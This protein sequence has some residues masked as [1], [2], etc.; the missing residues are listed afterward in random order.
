LRGARSRARPRDAGAPVGR[1]LQE[2]RQREAGHHGA[3]E[4]G[5]G[6]SAREILERADDVVHAALAK[7][8]RHAFEAGGGI[9]DIFGGDRHLVLEFAGGPM[10]RMGEAAQ[11]L[12][13]GGFLL[14]DDAAGL[15]RHA[16]GKLRHLI[17]RVA[18]RGRG[19]IAQI[20]GLRL[21]LVRQP[22]GLAPDLVHGLARVPA[23]FL[24]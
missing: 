5:D 4:E 14:L 10:H 19:L 6:L 7:G 8:P 24:R 11:P 1:A 3:A 12:G 23:R 21:G 20:A 17:L 2:A 15:V 13:P 22:V 16:S 18:Q 9:A